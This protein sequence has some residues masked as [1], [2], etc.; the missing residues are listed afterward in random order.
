MKQI[1]KYRTDDGEEFDTKEQ[2]EDH[3][4]EVAFSNYLYNHPQLCWS[5]PDDISC[6]EIAR[7]ILTNYIVIPKH[8]A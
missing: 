8:E 4:K 6:D 7:A 3:E 5:T 2:A 1:T